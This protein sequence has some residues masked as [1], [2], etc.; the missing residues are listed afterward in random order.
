MSP[1]IISDIAKFLASFIRIRVSYS[2]S[3]SFCL[4]GSSVSRHNCCKQ[5]ISSYVWDELKKIF[6]LDASFSSRLYML[7][8]PLICPSL[9][10]KNG[11]A[12]INKVT[13]KYFGASLDHK[14]DEKKIF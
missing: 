11:N 7:S 3:N 13:Q 6:G 9:L 12:S 10:S 4:I 5:C 14:S 2:S 1:S 8:S